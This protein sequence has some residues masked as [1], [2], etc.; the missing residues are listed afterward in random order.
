[1]TRRRFP[2]AV[3]RNRPCLDRS[4]QPP[5]WDD[6]VFLLALWLGVGVAAGVAWVL[7]A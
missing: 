7:Y 3:I 6:R 1:M 5:S 2:P 4:P